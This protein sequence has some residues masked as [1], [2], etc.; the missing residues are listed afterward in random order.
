MATNRESGGMTPQ[1]MRASGID[2][3]ETNGYLEGEEEDVMEQKLVEI[4]EQSLG[5][6][7]EDL[8]EWLSR[9]LGKAPHGRSSV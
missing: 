3:M 5:P 1:M 9:H 8:A 2:P 6:L 7:K 4:Q